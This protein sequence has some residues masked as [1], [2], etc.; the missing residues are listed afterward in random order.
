MT[1]HLHV[2]TDFF[3]L[4]SENPRLTGRCVILFSQHFSG[5]WIC[6]LLLLARHDACRSSLHHLSYLNLVG[7]TLRLSDRVTGTHITQCNKSCCPSQ[8]LLQ[9][10]FSN[11]LIHCG[12][13][14]MQYIDHRAITDSLFYRITSKLARPFTSFPFPCIPSLLSIWTSSL[15]HYLV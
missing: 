2:G 4:S 13:A 9:S 12:I 14:V 15:S 8:E 6:L 11:A 3:L 5:Q 7:V 1:Q 10:T